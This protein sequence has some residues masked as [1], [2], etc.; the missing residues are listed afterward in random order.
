MREIQ[1]V[2]P[3]STRFCQQRPE[4]R[5]GRAPVCPPTSAAAYSS[6]SGRSHQARSPKLRPAGAVLRGSH[7]S[8]PVRKRRAADEVTV[9]NSLRSRQM[10]ESSRAII[11]WANAL[12]GNRDNRAAAH[13]ANFL[14]AVSEDGGEKCRLPKVRCSPRTGSSVVRVRA[15]SPGNANSS[16]CRASTGSVAR[17]RPRR[18]LAAR[19]R[20]HPITSCSSPGW[21]R[22]AW[23]IS[24]RDS[25]RSHTPR[26]PNACVTVP[27]RLLICGPAPALVV[28][29]E[30]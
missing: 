2:A 25:G 11:R 28:A 24:S 14:A 5:T 6:L 3:P 19:R 17:S 26:C 22:P 23:R 8:S 4:P 29:I 15:I 21:F 12:A 10:Q 13:L 30:A 9:R 20:L 16:R 7:P 27:A 1:P 18:P